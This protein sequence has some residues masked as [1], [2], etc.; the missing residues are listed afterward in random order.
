MTYRELMH[1]HITERRDGPFRVVIRLCDQSRIT[2]NHYNVD[3]YLQNLSWNKHML[4]KDF[5]VSE[6]GIS[7]IH[8]WWRVI[9][10]EVG[11]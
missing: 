9:D 5:L 11:V 6:F 2:D 1:S 3:E 10:S 7:N 4:V 8:I